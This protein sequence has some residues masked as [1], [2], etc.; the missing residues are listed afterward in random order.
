MSACAMA[1]FGSTKV[2]NIH[3]AGAGAFEGLV[4]N[5]LGEYL[6]NPDAKVSQPRRPCWH[7]F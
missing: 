5:N 6:S 7:R 2:V 4:K 3:R 1:L